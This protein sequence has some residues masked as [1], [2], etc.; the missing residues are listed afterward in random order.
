MWMYLLVAVY[1]TEAKQIEL[2]D[3][4][5]IRGYQNNRPIELQNI[6]TPTNVHKELQRVGLTDSVLYSK[7][8]L[9]LRWIGLDDWI[10]E[11][12]FAATDE[13]LKYNM[14]HL[15]FHGV[16]T[17]ASV[18]LNGASIGDTDNMFTRYSFNIKRDLRPLMLNTLSVE[19]KSPLKTATELAYKNRFS[20][21][22]LSRPWGGEVHAHMLRKT[23]ISFGWSIAPAVPTVGLWKPVVIELTNTATIRD[24]GYTLE[25][26][27]ISWTIKFQIHLDLGTLSESSREGMLHIEFLSVKGF[28]VE[29]CVKLTTDQNGEFTEV[30]EMTIPK[31]AVDR[32]WPRGQGKQKL[33]SV[34]VEFEEHNPLVPKGLYCS[35]KLLKV[36]FRTVKIETPQV[37]AQGLAFIFNINDEEVFA[38]GA[39]TLPIHVYPEETYNKSRLRK[40]FR[41]IID[42]NM[43]MIRVWAGGLYESD[44]FYD[45]ADKYGILVWQDAPFPPATYPVDSVFL[46]S[47]EKEVRQNARRLQ[48]HPSLVVYALNSEIELALV[49]DWYLTYGKIEEFKQNYIKL[50]N[51]TVRQM[52]LVNDFS[53]RP[54]LLTTPGYGEVNPFEPSTFYS[55]SPNSR[56]YGDVHFIIRNIS[57]NF[58]NQ[59]H[60]TQARFISEFG[61]Q[62]LA[63]HR[64]WQAILDPREDLA[65]QYEHRQRSFEDRS[66]MMVQIE[67]NLPQLDRAHPMYWDHLMYF[68]QISQ[69]MQLKAQ[70]S[71]YR[72]DKGRH[73]SF[74]TAGALLWHL[75]DVWTA[76]TMSIIDSSG[77][78]KIAWY[79]LKDLFANEVVLG[80]VN[81]LRLE[82]YVI[83]ETPAEHNYQV[84]AKF[85]KKN[86]LEPLR[87]VSFS[88]SSHKKSVTLMRSLQ[89]DREVDKSEN[90]KDIFIELKLFRRKGKSNLEQVS[91]DMEFLDYFQKL[92][93]LADPKLDFNIVH[94]YCNKT[95]PN[96]LSIVSIAITVRAPAFFI[97]LEFLNPNIRDFYF[98]NNGFVQV[99]PIKTIYFNYYE[100]Q[101]TKCSRRIEKKDF[102]IWHLKN[103]SN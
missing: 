98:S 45:L 24:V 97:F 58:W 53:C 49:E 10:F 30:V 68:S 34:L 71:S 51:G 84:S 78:H 55:G 14:I 57:K 43:N 1:F 37:D 88:C 38:K 39:S 46:N 54:I 18:R 9:I 25:E 21:P 82:I 62:S 91:R 67:M 99:E 59:S 31:M 13:F 102:E 79:Y 60:H 28:K 95:E 83:N 80:L 72:T 74:Y 81:G 56:Y 41:T 35:Q 86:R 33:Y 20:C 89:I 12:T 94:Q 63:F 61:V 101:E 92:S 26:S 8:D 52:I 96:Q 42:A 36:A 93:D 65:V 4:W 76:P 40:F 7:N 48:R 73:N 50:F 17:V 27:M 69:A 15:T 90:F 47:V 5:I 22:P 100:E 85:F 87:E 66:H 23:Q 16:D 19:L 70:L 2:K 75:N 29:R 11:H 3:G 32:W 6:S 64:S 103:Y 77:Q 44:E